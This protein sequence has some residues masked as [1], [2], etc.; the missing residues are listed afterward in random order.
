M[1][2]Y[3]GRFTVAADPELRRAIHAAGREQRFVRGEKIQAAGTLHPEGPILIIK[4]GF[5]STVANSADGQYTLLSIRGPGDLVGEQ[6]LFGSASEAHGLT[7][8]GMGNGSA[9]RVRQDR[10]RQILYNHPQGWEV[11]ARHLHTRAEAAEERICLMAGQTAS[12]RLAVFILQLLAYGQAPLAR[13][14]QAQKVPLPLS[15][16]ELA[17]WIGVT[18]ETVERIISGWTRRGMVQT[19]RRYLLIRDVPQLEKIADIRRDVATKAA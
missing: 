3:Q 2:D 6:A 14:D 19:G 9:W 11:I 5:A 8:T 15:Q 1:A 7:V 18:R 16:A 12:R 17:E 10:F 13:T 4:S